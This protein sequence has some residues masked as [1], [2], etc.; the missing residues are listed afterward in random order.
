[1]N[2]NGVKSG[3]KFLLKNPGLIVR[4]VEKGSLGDDKGVRAG[5]RL[6]EINGHA[7]RECIDV[8]FYSADV[9]IDCVFQ[10]D[11][12][13]VAIR[14]HR[15][16]ERC[17]GLDF[18]PM[19]FRGCGN[20]C[21]FC[22]VDQNPPGLRSSLYFKDEDYRLSFLYGNYVTLTRVSQEDLDRIA[23]QRLSPLYISVHAVNTKVRKRLLG[24]K[25]HDRLMEKI[26]FLVAH[27]IELHGQIV[28]CPGWND[29]EVLRETVKE[30]SGLFPGF[31]SLALVPVGLTRHRKDQEHLQGYTS[32]SAKNLIDLM[33][34]AQY[35]FI[36]EFGEPFVYLADEFF[37]LA[38]RLLPEHSHYGDFWQME[39]GVGM[40]RLFIDNF[41]TLC[42]KMEMKLR[43]SAKI[44]IVTGVLAQP[45]LA[46]HVIPRLR[47]I[48]NLQVDLI[49]VHN[50]FFGESVTV[51][52]LL[53]AG[54]ILESLRDIS[55][56]FVVF[57]PSNCLNTDA[58][59]L[60][61]YTV[62]KF[63]TELN[64]R[65]IVSDNFSE[66]WKLV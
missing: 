42:K 6:M 41:E 20:K 22:F 60:D 8:Q 56:D 19:H 65:V 49:P 50:R 38:D 12:Q 13:T 11:D 31:R 26:R 25:H 66:V 36:K 30:L 4:A 10:R 57:L 28:L 16:E 52:G 27:G 9:I 54:D 45:V 61:D 39:N 40:T 48:T 17:L 44:A 59:F 33:R 24:L 15:Q 23:E 47:K 1:M 43:R 55:D 21:V 34:G 35:T 58:L 63:G 14:F 5:D 62:K 64:R 2:G 53:T 29:G 18:E 3:R 46:R 37:L 32:A 51:T 7:I